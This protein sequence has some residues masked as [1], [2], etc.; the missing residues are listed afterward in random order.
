MVVHAKYLQGAGA[1]AVERA[2]L[3]NILHDRPELN[4]IA[5]HQAHSAFHRIKAAECGELSEQEGGV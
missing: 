5:R 3:V 1:V 4:V 2:G